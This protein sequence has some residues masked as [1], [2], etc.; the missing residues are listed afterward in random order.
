MTGTFDRRVFLAAA[1]AAAPLTASIAKGR[2]G[3]VRA[4][5]DPLRTAGDGPSP[6][7][8]VGYHRR[9]SLSPTHELVEIDAGEAPAKGSLQT[10]FDALR[11]RHGILN[12]KLSSPTT[13]MQIRR[14]SPESA[15]IYPLRVTSF[16]CSC[17]GRDED[18]AAAQ[19][20]ER[21]GNLRIITQVPFMRKGNVVFAIRS[22]GLVNPRTGAFESVDS[23]FNGGIYWR[24]R[25]TG[26][27]LDYE[28]LVFRRGKDTFIGRMSESLDLSRKVGDIDPALYQAEVGY[29]LD[30][31]SNDSAGRPTLTR[32]LELYGSSARIEQVTSCY[33]ASAA[34]GAAAKSGQGDLMALARDARNAC[35]AIPAK[36]S[37]QAYDAWLYGIGYD[38]TTAA[39]AAA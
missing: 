22:Q 2:V 28:L 25:L 33:R 6:G 37:Y 16:T 36:R 17:E 30:R 1:V 10:E 13:E 26:Q 32:P 31:E 34:F 24:G 23:L 21:L 9:Y 39:G 18:G 15:G 5:G 27:R 7:E 12:E 11:R 19:L 38:P 35:V 29:H 4:S 8:R 3:G 20:T 14:S